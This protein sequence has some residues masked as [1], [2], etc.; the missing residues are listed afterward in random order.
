[1]SA[2]HSWQRVDA[3]KAT[4]RRCGFVRLHIP[5]Y[6]HHRTMF[7]RAGIIVDSPA[8]TPPCDGTWPDGWRPSWPE[9]VARPWES[10]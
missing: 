6:D 2:R 8:A 9:G 1:M 4:C 5:A 10:A 3:H 7:E